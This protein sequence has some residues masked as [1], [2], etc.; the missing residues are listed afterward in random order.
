LQN[1][2]TFLGVNLYNSFYSS[3]ST[4]FENLFAT[5]DVSIGVGS[6]PPANSLFNLV[7]FQT[8]VELGETTPNILVET[9]LIYGT[10]FTLDGNWDILTTTLGLSNSEQTYLIWLWLQTAMTQTWNRESDGGDSQTG[11]LSN[12]AAGSL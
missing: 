5:Y 1:Q 11:Y 6:E 12:L 10:D 7:N 3:S 8:L 9:S 4:N 2:A